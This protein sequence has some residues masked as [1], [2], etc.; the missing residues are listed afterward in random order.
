[1]KAVSKT[2]LMLVV[3]LASVCAVAASAQAVTTITPTGTAV[4]ASA[5]NPTFTYGGVA[6]TCGSGTLVGTTRSPAAT[7]ISLTV[8]FQGLCTVAVFLT[9]TVSC[10]NTITLQS[11][12]V[13]TSLF[14][15]LDTGFTCTIS[16][17]GI[18]NIDIEGLQFGS[19]A[20]L[21]ETATT[22]TTTM[23]FDATRT[24]SASCGPASGTISLSASYN[25]TPTALA[26]T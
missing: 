21:N 23:N 24:G 5:A 19:L 1:M 9:A 11:S 26:I 7:D 2:G 6:V 12:G 22:L 4:S 3:A 15:T 17:S 10:A 16:V 13:A 18:C 25:V 8:S 14:Y 20:T